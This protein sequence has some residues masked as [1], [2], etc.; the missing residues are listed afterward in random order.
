MQQGMCDAL[1]LNWYETKLS[2]GERKQRGHFSTP[3][4]L[5]D[6]MLDACGYTAS[7][8]LGRLRLLDPACGSGNFLARAAHRLCQRASSLGLS[9]QQTGLLV[10]RNLWGL[11]PDPVACCLADLQVRSVLA[12]HMHLTSPSLPLHIHQADSLT[13]PWQPCVDML[14]A[15]P[16]YLAAKNTDLSHYHQARQRGQADSYLLFLNLALR[17]V[18]PGGWIGLVLPDPVLARANAA[19]ERMNLLH[20][21]SVHAIWHLSGVFSAEVG[22]VVLIAQKTPPHPLHR[23]SWT[24]SQWKAEQRLNSTPVHSQQVSQALLIRQPGAELRYLSG[25]VQGCALERL[26]RAVD[27]PQKQTDG[28]LRLLPL[29]ELVTIKRGE[30][31]GRASACLVPL[32]SQAETYPVLRGGVDLRPYARPDSR[33]GIA[34]TSI[35]KPLARYLETKLLIVKSTSRL[36]AAL[37]TRGHVVL[38]TL[39][40][41][42]LHKSTAQSSRSQGFSQATGSVDEK[43]ADDESSSGH[44]PTSPLCFSG[45]QDG[46]ST[47]DI[48]YFL[49][50]L[51]NSRLLQAYVYHLHTAYKLVQPQIE[52]AVLTRLPV[53][54]GAP[55]TRFAIAERARELE[56]AC[57]KAGTVVKWDEHFT[58]LYE[59][60][61]RAIRA[62]YAAALPEA[63]TDKGVV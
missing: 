14:M 56:Q 39:Y 10:Q 57:S 35:K 22:A 23:I 49:L 60:Q 6:Q 34:G 9:S 37:D 43:T 48:Y 50:A 38:Q 30:E 15:N 36:Q 5:V 1:P 18:R 19:P 44:L 46:E 12:A 20:E 17:I 29:E 21:C 52:Q 24:R 32:T 33:L 16:P 2:S 53:P 27:S 3:H 62:L 58:S 41:L 42:H 26:R 51:L 4:A 7:A 31:I 55:R 54:W 8:D 63:F 13:L 45:E 47:I 28:P 11:D 40:L 25:C 61:E 59:E